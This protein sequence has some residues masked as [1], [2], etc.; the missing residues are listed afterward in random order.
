MKKRQQN[1]KF[2]AT[3]GFLLKKCL[4]S[5][6]IFKKIILDEE[7]V[8]LGKGAVGWFR[9]MPKYL[10]PNSN[11]PYKLVYFSLKVVIFVCFTKIVNISTMLGL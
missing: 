8:T 2:L 10:D 11:I 5:A 3:P 4:D 9:P 7:L 6:R 1:H